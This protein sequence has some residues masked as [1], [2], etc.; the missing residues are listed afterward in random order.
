MAD[1]E[2]FDLV[3]VGA[4]PAGMSAAIAARAA[5]VGSVLILD[6][7]AAPGGQIYRRHGA[8]FAVADP[9]EAGR[10]Y[11]DGEDLIAAARRSGAAI[12]SRAV[13]WG[14]WEKRLAYVRDDGGRAGVAGR[15]IVLA[16]GA[17]D[18]PVAFPGWTLPGVITA[19]AAK[20]LVAVQRV[21]P[22][23]RILMAGSG[24]LALAFSAQLRGLGANIVA[25]AEAAPRPGMA[26]LARLALHA[27]PALL[28]EAIGHRA[29]LWRERI[30]FH[31]STVIVRAEGDEEVARAVIAGVDGDWRVVPG[32]ERTLAVDTILLGYGLESSAELARLMGCALHF[33]RALGGWLPVKDARMRT[34]LPGIYAAG[35]GSG[36]GGALHAIAEGEIAGVAAAVELGALAAREAAAR[37]AGP[38][39]RL[40][41]LR[42]FRQVLN[43]LYRPGDGLYELATAATPVCRCEERTQAD[44]DALL[45][46][47]VAD[48]NVVRARIRVGMGRCQGRNC[49]SHVAATI[50]R[51]RG[52][53][54][55]DVPPLS[56]RPPVK[57]VSIAAIAAEREQHAAAV[58][59][60]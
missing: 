51:R 33:D 28:W 22:G 5:G 16:T 55:A 54:V 52:M 36:V 9:H 2:E 20:T 13:V 15:C 58:E 44:L 35:D 47:D 41:R 42:R 29:E 7:G 38:E 14:A 8:G 43:E 40:R 46:E 18:R 34:S 31:H 39:R 50:A 56:V 19:G 27:P 59:V 12:R 57:P 23:R 21:L 1:G 3:I 4:G 60:S 11:R 24:P 32:S 53:P 25:V 17:R 49:A 6:E 45:A 30:P 48:P 26:A 37:L 10:E